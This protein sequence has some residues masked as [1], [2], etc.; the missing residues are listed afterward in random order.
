MALLIIENG[1]K[2]SKS[3]IKVV[4]LFF[5][6][7]GAANNEAPTYSVKPTKQIKR[8]LTGCLDKRPSQQPKTIII[9][10]DLGFFGR[11]EKA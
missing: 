5:P 6:S 1:N 4:L 3:L 7:Y 8:E 11:L 10:L 9:P 2:I